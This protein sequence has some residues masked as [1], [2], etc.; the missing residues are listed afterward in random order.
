MPDPS[1]II[2]DSEAS[3]VRPLIVIPVYNHSGTLRD[4]VTGALN[5]CDDVLVIDDGSSDGN[6]G[7]ALHN[8]PVLFIRH[9]KNEGK[10]AAI[11]TAAREAK[12][13]GMTHIITIDADGQHDP[14]DFYRFDR[15]IRE[16]PLAIVVGKR[17]FDEKTV[18]FSSRFG[19]AFSN[20]WLKVQTG[21]SLKDTQS[22]FRAYPV[23]VLEWLKLHDRRFSFEVEVLVKA[24]WAGIP[25]KEVDISVHYPEQG[26]RISHFNPF[27]D[28][29]ALTILNTRLT[30][31]ALLPI[32][33]RNYAEEKDGSEKITILH[34]INSM[35]TLLRRN[36]SPRQL[37]L[38]AGLGV[39]LGS[40]PLIACQTL[41]ILVT[42]SYFRLS[43]FAA[44]STS[45]LCIPPVVP[46]LCI[47]LGYFIRHGRFLTEISLETIGYQ[48]L[49]R[50]FEWIIGAFILGPVLGALVGAVVYVMT[51]LLGK[52]KIRKNA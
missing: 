42:A 41:T 13:L 19:R 43:K 14:A 34:P 51:L 11:L 3:P 9:E 46:A 37:A 45:Q 23:A 6:V 21:R 1:P 25:L 28:N 31:R 2:R 50:I 5:A 35:K 44:L 32:P 33:Q 36:V 17:A 10:G 30:M 18:P 4:V 15:M 39:F 26:K 27:R 8:L 47:E 22:G 48:G 16:E 20:F 52:E 12:R 29:L 24:A 40:L 7:Q 38:S 49:E